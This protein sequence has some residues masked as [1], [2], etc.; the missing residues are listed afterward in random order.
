MD[1]E[2]I[3]E[4]LEQIRAT[5]PEEIKQARW[6][7]KE[8]EEMLAEAQRE[9][10]RIIQQARERQERL[11]SDDEVTKQADRAP[12]RSSRM[13]AGASARSCSAPRIT[14]TDPQH[15]RGQPLEVQRRR[16]ARP[17]PPRGEGHTAGVVH[18]HDS[19]RRSAARS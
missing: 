18:G 13:P 4:I 7:V 12:R 19:L 6:V 17:R 5:I 11:I 3:D 8:Q 15:A 2:R 10:E 16:S 14:P 1:K 9:A